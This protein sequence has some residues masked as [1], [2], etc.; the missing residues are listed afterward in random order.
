MKLKNQILKQYTGT[1]I[2]YKTQM[3][4]LIIND[5]IDNTLLFHK[6]VYYSLSHKVTTIDEISLFSI[7]HIS[8]ETCDFEIDGVSLKKYDIVHVIN[9]P[10]YNQD[11]F[12]ISRH[13][14]YKYAEIEASFTAALS[15]NSKQKV[16]NKGYVLSSAKHIFEKFSFIRKL[17]ALG[18]KTPEVVTKYNFNLENCINKIYFPQPNN[19]YLLTLVLTQK[20][21]YSD[22]GFDE[23][24]ENNLHLKLL[25]SKT[26]QLMVQME[27][28]LCAIPVTIVNGDLFAFGVDYHLPS[29]LNLETAAK[30]LNEII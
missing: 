15:Q 18:W 23:Y 22:I 17:S 19:E 1:T 24:I 20:S 5:Q 12:K 13:M 27:L 21:V 14:L 10:R 8:K 25:I 7:N 26:Q 2:Q 4:I 16:I 9:F 3:N 29:Y 11:Y 30:I 28:S 6:E